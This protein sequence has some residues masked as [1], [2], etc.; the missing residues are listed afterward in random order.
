MLHKLELLVI[1]FLIS[2]FV[3]AQ[4]D[5]TAFMRR[6]CMLDGVS[7][8]RR[9]ESDKYNEKY[10]LRFLQNVNGETD[11]YGTF[12][13]RIVVSFRG[14]DRPTVLV[15]E[16]YFAD[17]ALRSGYEEELARLTDANLIVVEYRYFAESVP[18][19]VNW[20]YMTVRNSLY[21]YHHV[22]TV[23][24]SL[25][26]DKWISTG[27][28]KGGQTTMFYRAFYPEDVDVSVSY[29]APL[30]KSVEDGRHEKFLSKKVGT[31]TERSAVKNAQKE[32]MRRK[33]SCLPLFSQ[34][35]KQ[36]NLRYYISES[37]IYDYV[38][39][40]YPFALWQWGESVKDI[41]DYE[42]SDTV[43][44]DYLAKI[45]GPDYFSV[46]NK[47]LP[48]DVQAA[49]ELGYYGY[50]DKPIKKWKSAGSVKGYLKRLMLP[51]SL[52]SITF[53]K[54]LYETTTAFLRNEDPKHIFIYGENDPW[55]A[56]GVCQ[57]LDCSKKKNMSIYV[58]PRGS[59]KARIGT[60]PQELREEIIDKIRKW[61]KE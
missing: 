35:N 50:D 57:W 56:S 18:S 19:Q 4:S 34:Y 54:S 14:Y 41:P 51:D 21:D 38:V 7:D 23:F 61:L 30:N 16:G 9:I 5:T 37:D 26:T 33:K 12:K 52:R 20:D 22:R 47:F 40:E 32:F 31:K 17:Y 42:A 29:V 24:G 8:V 6:L 28:S 2:L 45:T 36:H 1:S 43:W 58:Q 60:M 10:V 11:E 49:R 44:F 46:P 55:S 27:I 13:Q 25:F 15:T 48:F 3:S 39:L 59:H 53:D